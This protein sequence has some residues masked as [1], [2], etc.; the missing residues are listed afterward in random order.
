M[1]LAVEYHG[2]ILVKYILIFLAV[3]SVSRWSSDLEIEIHRV[4]RKPERTNG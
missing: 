1:F 3:L 4:G 2:F